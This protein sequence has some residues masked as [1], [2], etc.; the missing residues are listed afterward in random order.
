MR[1]Q[2]KTHVRTPAALER[3]YRFDKNF[4]E[5]KQAGA[6]AQKSADNAQKSADN[7]Q[8]GADEAKKAADAIPGELALK[9]GRD[10]NDQVISMIN[11]SAN[12]IKL[13]SNRLSV[14]SDNFKLSEDGTLEATNA[15][16]GNKTDKRSVEIG[17]GLISLSAPAETMAGSDTNVSYVLLLTFTNGN[18]KF[19]LYVGGEYFPVDPEDST[20]GVYWQ[21]SG[22]ITIKEI[23]E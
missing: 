9:L 14:E 22:S 11:A 6:Q 8:K 15:K 3:K 18:K 16:I 17:D 20:S 13:K 21:P 7:A 12:V 23:T 2:D 1:K 10:E 19:G 5:T 4:A